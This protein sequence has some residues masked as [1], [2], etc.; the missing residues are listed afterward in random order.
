MTETQITELQF[1]T[2][3]SLTGHLV[4]S[5]APELPEG[6]TYRLNIQHPS[7]VDG[8][9]LRAATITA[10]IGSMVGSEWV[11]EARFSEIT[12]AHMQGATVAACI[13]A[14]EVWDA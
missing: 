11:E 13:H 14:Y 12:R 10:R 5:G 8:T 9:P 3:Q 1:S 7:G 6:Y 4:R 2:G